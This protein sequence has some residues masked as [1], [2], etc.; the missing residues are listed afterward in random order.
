MTPATTDSLI[1]RGLLAVLVLGLVGTGVELLLLKHVDGFWQVA[2]VVAIAAAT[3]NVV[4]VAMTK[5]A[6][7]LRVLQA[8]MLVFLISGIIGVYLHF[9]TNVL[10][11]RESNP[12]LVGAELYKMALM[13]ATPTL[14][15]GTMIQ[16]GL[17]GLLFAFRHPSL[18]RNNDSDTHP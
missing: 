4:W 2:P 9:D 1:R 5:S 12:S 13:G 10:D 11:E 17:V 8:I 18:R 15:P 3:L 7:S 6:A 14:A 16:L